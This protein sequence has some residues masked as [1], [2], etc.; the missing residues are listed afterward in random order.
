MGEPTV[1]ENLTRK[2]MMVFSGTCHPVLSE[3]IA[4]HLGIK[5]C[6]AR[7]RR[8]SD[9]EIYFRANESVRGAD[10]FVIQTHASPINESLMEQLV[11]LDALKR[12]SAKRITAVIPYY[13]YSR[14]DKK[15]LAREPISAKLVA[16]LLTVAGAQRVL[17]VDL[18]SGQI[19]GFFN[20]PVDHLTALPLLGDFLEKHLGLSGDDLVVVANTGDDIEIHGGH[21][22][23]DPD[24]VTYWL[25]DRIDERGWGLAGD[26]FAVMD[27]MRDL[28]VDTEALIYSREPQRF[29]YPYAFDVPLESWVYPVI[30]RLAGLGLIR[31]ELYGSVAGGLRLEDPGADL[32]ISAAL[33]SSATG[34]PAGE[35]TVFIGEVSLTGAVR[36]ARAARRSRR[37]DRRPDHRVRGIRTGHGP[38]GGR[39]Q[40]PAGSARA[41][42]SAC[43]RQQWR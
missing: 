22:S 30:D 31:A 27:G 21:V 37:R 3:E 34:R 39:P 7:I 5:L 2:R 8:F 25:A 16:D 29:K 36:R 1:R 17:S 14:Q 28:G 10:V 24:L 20:F 43:T 23:P 41:R 18:H 38:G 11:M 40:L 26:T 6:E 19:Q 32:A 12:A 42:G 33:A 9:G 4:Q 13:G 35:G 15:T